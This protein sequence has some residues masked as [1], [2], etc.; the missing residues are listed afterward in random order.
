MTILYVI[1]AILAVLLLGCV[2]FVVWLLKAM[3]EAWR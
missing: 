1:I 3:G 2:G